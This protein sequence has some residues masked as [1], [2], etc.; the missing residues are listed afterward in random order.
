MRISVLLSLAAVLALAAPLCAEATLTGI[1]L[2]AH[3]LGP[4][5][6][7]AS[8]QGKVV[9]FEYWGV[10]CPPCVASIPHLAEL[11]HKHGSDNFVIVANH[12]QGADEA[13]VSTLWRAKGGGEAITVINH[14]ELSGAQVSGIPRCFLFNHEGKL[15]F[16]GYPSDVASHVEAAMKASPGAL[17]AG[18]E[19]TKQGKHAAAIG[20][21]R[22]NL[23]PS[24]KA[25][26]K[27]AESG[28]GA[29]Q[30]EAQW[31]LA[32]VE[33]WAQAQLATITADRTADPFSAAQSLART[34]S[35]LKGDV[36]GKPFEDLAKELKG[37]KPFQTELKA[38]E[39]LAGIQ[40]MA[41]KI[42]LGADPEAKNRKQQCADIAAALQA[43]QKKFPGTAAAAKAPVLVRTWGL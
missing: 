34:S 37:D 13:A 4:K 36:L 22:A 33:G 32:K 2:G 26:R 39:M 3:V 38:G 9:L 11:A 14:G 27:D 15:V 1:N 29:A 18:R 20:G 31:L 28:T 23:A 40:A 24:L 43:L 17:V 21:M 5:H 7:A 41:A 8:L 42:G 19:F 30:E 16:D 35:L 6:T 12:C 25:L 10:N